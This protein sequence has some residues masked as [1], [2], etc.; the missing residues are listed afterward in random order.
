MSSKSANYCYTTRSRNVGLVL[1]SEVSL[2]KTNDL[3]QADY[4]AHKLPKGKHSVRGLGMVVP[5]PKT[6]VT[7]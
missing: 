5:D 3:V 6:H 7:L 1:L 2:G 4:E